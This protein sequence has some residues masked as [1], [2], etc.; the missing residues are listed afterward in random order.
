MNA[1]PTLYA[2]LLTIAASSLLA[3]MDA[4]GKFLMGEFST[5]QVTWARFVFHVAIVAT[6]F[7]LQGYRD[8]VKTR[9]P[10]AQL[11]RGACM[12]GINT[13]LYFAIQT[14][15]LAEAT[16]LMYLAPVLVTVLAGAWLK[17]Q[18]TPRHVFAV[19]TGFCGVLII[20]RP[21]FQAFDPAMLLA[22]GASVLLALYFL[23]TRKV[24]GVDDPRTSLFY[25]SIVGAVVLSTVVPLTWKSPD[26]SQWLLLAGM[27]AL[28]AAGHFLLIKAYSLLPASELSPWLNAQVIAATV[29]SVVVFRDVLGWNFF[30]GAS[31]IV[32]SGLLLRLGRSRLGL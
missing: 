24:S 27:G 16:A 21:G 2:I 19:V 6:I 22:F 13:A 1:H 18:V 10:K 31:L 5:F 12:T 3:G 4:L 15:S 17:E 25:T 30:V 8:F 11:A 29:F 23:L 7:V 32:G 26:P 9:A 28:G 20:I 14:V